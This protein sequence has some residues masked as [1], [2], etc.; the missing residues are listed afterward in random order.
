VIEWDVDFAFQLLRD[1]TFDTDIL[2]DAVSQIRATPQGLTRDHLTEKGS[3]CTLLHDAVSHVG[4]IHPG[5]ITLLLQCGLSPADLDNFGNDVWTYLQ[6]PISITDL[7]A[8]VNLIQFSGSH[9]RVISPSV[10]PARPIRQSILHVLFQYGLG[11]LIRSD[12]EFNGLLSD[13]LV[14]LLE[15]F[16]NNDVTLATRDHNGLLPLEVR[17]HGQLFE[18]PALDILVKHEIVSQKMILD[19]MTRVTDEEIHGAMIGLLYKHK[20][21]L[22]GEPLPGYD[23]GLSVLELQD[24]ECVFESYLELLLEER[25]A[26][27]DFE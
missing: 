13:E 6:R 26:P 10:W 8:V 17:Y 18:F 3:G 15:L 2:A 11:D 4:D 20:L 23:C 24:F 21:I 19:M 27:D 12:Y 9:Y 5:V 7:P 22:H 14:E 25:A 1:A 16:F